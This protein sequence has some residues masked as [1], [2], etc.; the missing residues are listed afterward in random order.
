MTTSDAAARAFW[1]ETP[2]HY[3]AA[4]G[5]GS[6]YALRAR[7]VA[8]KIAALRP[9]AR[10]LDLGC[11]GG[12]LSAA[13]ASRG[14]DVYGA[15]ISPEMLAAARDAT[16]GL[17]DEPKYRFRLIQGSVAPFPW[18]FAVVIV[19][20]VFPYVPDY[21]TYVRYLSGL[22]EPG[23]LIVA[24]CTRR[25]SL[26]AWKE[27]LSLLCRHPK[28]TGWI[29]TVRNLISSGLW[30]GGVAD[31]A[32]ARQVHDSRSFDRLFARNGYRMVSSLELYH[33]PKWDETAEARGRLSQ[34]AARRLGWCHVGFY[35][36]GGGSPT[37]E[38]RTSA[39]TSVIP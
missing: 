10:V 25:A 38:W 33:W 31:R 23:G 32:T 12:L 1:I 39:A 20:G 3:L 36:E 4:S 35:S 21:E 9:G 7:L 11:G 24:S 30:S 34:A 17:L 15:D 14:F 18:R 19:L 2:D 29:R 37:P 6:F 5:P 22:V 13:L 27:T 8:E 28:P 16:R 26:F